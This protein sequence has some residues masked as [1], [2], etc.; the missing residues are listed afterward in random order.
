MTNDE[1]RALADCLD[2]PNAMQRTARRKAA[3]YLRAQADA[4]PVGILTVAR[5]RGHLEN[6]DFDY[7]GELP[8]G[9]YPLYAAPAAPQA[10]PKRE[11]LSDERIA[12]IQRAAYERAAQECDEWMKRWQATIGGTLGA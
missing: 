6:R 9:N 7:T 10:D 2:D 5:F 12:E 4:Q 3:D 11:P 1:L 8:D